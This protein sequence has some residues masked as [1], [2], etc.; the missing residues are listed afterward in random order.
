LVSS[1]TTGQPF[2]KT[3]GLDIRIRSPSERLTVFRKAI[4]VVIALTALAGSAPALATPVST[5]VPVP[6]TIAPGGAPAQGIIM[7]D[8]GVCD[9]IR[10]MGC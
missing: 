1:T 8:G 3:A 2:A 7:R 4:P 5:T 9:P 10:H 6:T